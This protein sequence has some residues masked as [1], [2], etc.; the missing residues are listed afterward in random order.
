MDEFTK[1][2]RHLTSD[3]ASYLYPETTFASSDVEAI[4]MVRNVWEVGEKQISQYKKNGVRY[5]LIDHL[6][7]LKDAVFVLP[8]EIRYLTTN[9]RTG[10]TKIIKSIL[11]VSEYTKISY[12]IIY[13]EL[14]ENKNFNMERNGWS[15]H[16]QMINI[17]SVKKTKFYMY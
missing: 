4:S 9:L 2:I 13:R 8:T 17:E 15:I 10:Y 6:M 14:I 3:I 1:N 12:H 7:P 11:K 16:R 5:Y